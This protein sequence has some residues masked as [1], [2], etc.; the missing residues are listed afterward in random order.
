MEFFVEPGPHRSGTSTGSTPGSGGTP[1][2]ASTRITCVCTNIRWRSCR[3]T[4]PAPSTSSTSSGFHRQPVGRASGY[5]QPDRLRPGHA[6]K[7]FRR[8]SDLLRPGHRRA[9]PPY[10]IEPA[11]GL[12]RSFMAF[13]VDSYHE[14]EAP[15][16]RAAWTAHRAPAGSAP[17]A[18][19]GSGAV[20][21]QHAD[22]VARGRDLAEE[23][24]Q[25]WNIEFDD[26]GAIGRRYRRQD[27]IGTPFCVTG[28]TS[29]RFEGSGRHHSRARFDGPG[30]RGHRRGVQPGDPPQGSLTLCFPRAAVS[31]PATRRCSCH[32]TDAHAA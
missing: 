17:G 19:Q 8:R 23:L 25:S 29:T 32:N 26:A 18:G 21:A 13:L 22:F 4:A 1:T 30:T 24:R 31:V 2:S 9:L 28:W 10:V 14:D 16:P 12:T 20:V 15:T 11:A 7:A 27:E 6:R 3:T 5:R